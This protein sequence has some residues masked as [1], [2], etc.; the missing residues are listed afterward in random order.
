MSMMADLCNTPYCQK[1]ATYGYSCCH[2]CLEILRRPPIYGEVL[3]EMKRTKWIK[4]ALSNEI[5]EVSILQ[6]INPWWI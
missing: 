1:P 6:T 2:D 4:I 3:L 5:E